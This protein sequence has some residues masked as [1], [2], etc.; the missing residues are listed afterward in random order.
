MTNGHSGQI[1]IAT[2]ISDRQKFH[3]YFH[4]WLSIHFT[5]IGNLSMKLSLKDK[6]RHKEIY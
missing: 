3:L 5:I 1:L 6:R 4:F 2:N